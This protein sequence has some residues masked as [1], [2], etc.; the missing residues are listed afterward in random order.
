MDRK[1][2]LNLI[3]KVFGDYQEI[4]GQEATS[5]TED[6]VPIGGLPG[7]DTMNEVELIVMLSEHLPLPLNIRLCVSD[8]GKKAL[9]IREMVNH[10][11]EILN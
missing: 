7:F 9:S 4:S 2:I 8:D 11:L 10:L 6:T 3:M 5:I 1:E